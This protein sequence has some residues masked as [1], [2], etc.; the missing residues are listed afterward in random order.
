[1][2]G[3][4]ESQAGTP[5]IFASVRS[6]HTR[7]CNGR[8]FPD[9]GDRLGAA[10]GL[11]DYN[12]VELPSCNLPQA[13]FCLF[14]RAVKHAAFFMLLSRT[15]LWKTGSIFLIPENMLV[16]WNYRKFCIKHKI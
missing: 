4:S 9:D 8:V 15:F 7:Q 13:F 3:H 12:T 2:I 11:S 1:M 5:Q 14:Q 16:L 10:A 6:F